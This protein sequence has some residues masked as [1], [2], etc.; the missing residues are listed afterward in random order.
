M[1]NTY[2]TLVWV[3]EIHYFKNSCDKS[4][5]KCNMYPFILLSFPKC[6]YEYPRKISCALN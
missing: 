4:A 1:H 5:P 6:G 2:S 3:K